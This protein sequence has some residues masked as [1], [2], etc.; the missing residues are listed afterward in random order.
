MAS[1]C[2]SLSPPSPRCARRSPR[3]WS[4]SRRRRAP[5]RLS[6]GRPSRSSAISVVVPPISTTK[7]SCSPASARGADHARR[8]SGQNRLHR[9]PQRLL[10]GNQGAIPLHHHERCCDAFV[11]ENAADGDHEL[12]EQ[13]DQARVQDRGQGPSR[14]V[15]L[16]AQLMGASD[17]QAGERMSELGHRPFMGGIT[18]RRNIRRRQNA[19]TRPA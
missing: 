14:R 18:A 10:G 13:R 2:T 5:S 3:P 19:S 12:I 4:A 8:R 11:A 9:S 6:T 15:Q 16:G 7:T 17:R 1:R